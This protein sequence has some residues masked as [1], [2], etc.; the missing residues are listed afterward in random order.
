MSPCPTTPRHR[1]KWPSVTALVPARNE[2]RTIAATVAMLAAQ[3]YPGSF[4]IVVANDSS[5]D[6]TREAA[7]AQADGNPAVRVIDARPL[8][9][10]WAGKVWALNEAAAAAGEPDY[11]W[12]T[13]ADIVHRSGML[14]KLV[15]GATANHLDL[16]SELV[17]LRC[18][19][20]WEK[21]L[22]PAYY[23]YFA[24][25][26]PF[27]AVADPKARIAGA[28]GGSA[29]L[30]RSRLRGHRRVRGHPQGGHRRLRPRPRGQAKRRTHRAGAC[31]R[32]PFAARL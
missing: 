12:L 3:D 21:L 31:P 14:R 29:L 11:Y 8:P 2:A 27:R 24:L 18:R 15:A 25:I 30:R 6:G 26:Y 22:V 7:L 32:Q 20:L 10:G 17:R 16:A 19:S 5:E 9:G 23:Y 13:D 1:R 28:A 4:R